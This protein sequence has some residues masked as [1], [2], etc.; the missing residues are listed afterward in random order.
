MLK[1]SLYGDGRDE[2]EDDYI[3]GIWDIDKIPKGKR[4]SL[5]RFYEVLLG[6]D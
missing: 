2:Y 4:K 1:A 6:K 3:N 5:R